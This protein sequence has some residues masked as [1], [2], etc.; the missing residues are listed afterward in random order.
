MTSI[1]N[2]SNISKEK[3]KQISKKD[4]E[5]VSQKTRKL[6]ESEFK[7]RTIFNASPD[8]I[9]VTDYY[10]NVLDANQAWMNIIGVKRED[11]DK[12]NITDFYV[13]NNTEDLR[14][15][16]QEIRNGKEVKGIEIK[17]KNIAGVLFD[18]EINSLPV[19]KDGR[20]L[21]VINIARDITKRK[22][23]ERKLRDSEENYRLISESANDLIRVM[24]DKFEFDYI[25]EKVHKRLLGY[26][27]EDM[28]G[29][30]SLV[31]IHPQDR[32][33]VIR[34]TRKSLVFIHPQ[35]RRAVIRST[36][37]YLRGEKRSYEARFRSKN[38]EYKWFEMKAKVFYDDR[39]DMNILS[40][41]RDI[42]DRKL[43]EFKLKESEERYRLIYETAYDLIIVLDHE[44]KYDYINEN[45]F[46][47]ILGYSKDEII[48]K[49]PIEFI[50]PDDTTLLTYSLVEG[51]KTGIGGAELRFKHKNGNWIWLETKG[52]TFTDADGDLKAIIIS[53]DVTERKLNEQKTQ[54]SERKFR[55]LYNQ[56]SFYKDLFAHDISNVLHVIR[57]STELLSL[58]LSEQKSKEIEELIN[59]INKQ[60]KR[61]TKLMSSA[62]TLSELEESEISIRTLK[63]CDVLSD[64]IEYFKKTHE[65][66]N[67]KI[68]VEC[69]KANK[70]ILV[71]ASYLLQDIFDNILINAIIYNTS[72]Q[73]EILISLSSKRIE[74]VNYLKIEFKDNG[75]GISDEKKQLV[76]ERGNRELKGSKGMG[77]GLSIV[78]KILDSYQGKI[79][80]ED[81]VKGDYTKGTNF[82]LLLRE[83][84]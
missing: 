10:G 84:K 51:F 70:E 81:R 23:I 64:S 25:N 59:I 36:R 47:Q 20:I 15:Y 57:S 3:I 28:L 53:R 9:Y 32:R 68:E 41:A 71:K 44:F 22:E 8:I 30:M 58:Q 1:E 75:I 43:A 73:V 24:N 4:D 5:M 63:L 48:G 34:S 65:E 79:W 78:K 66:K 13:G 18:F 72:P 35:D 2:F 60:I 33:S 69:N 19:E 61:G 83:I 74:D 50:H 21:M 37:K 11:F 27:K 80:V 39:G 29:K 38:G 12:I 54:E 56:L 16:I 6:E 14:K 17:A 31:F 45:A 26:S 52:Q 82:I 62:F 76:F 77:L 42:N 55:Q 40:I 67:I 46:I 49:T 7:Y